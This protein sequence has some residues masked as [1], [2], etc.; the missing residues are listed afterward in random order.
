L[1]GM[2]LRPALRPYPTPPARKRHSGDLSRSGQD[3]PAVPAR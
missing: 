1:A 2:G 3:K